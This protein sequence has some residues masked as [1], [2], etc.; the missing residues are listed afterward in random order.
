MSEDAPVNIGAALVR[1]FAVHQRVLS[2]QIKLQRWAVTDGGRR[3][4]DVFN[5]VADPCFLVAAWERVRENR[6]AKTAGVDRATVVRS[7]N[8]PTVRKGFWNDCGRN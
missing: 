3:F 5:L 8:P 6:G 4:D 2:M 7:R 1:P